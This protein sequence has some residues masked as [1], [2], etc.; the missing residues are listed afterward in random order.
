MGALVLSSLSSLKW[1]M[2]SKLAT[3]SYLDSV[4]KYTIYTPIYNHTV[5]LNSKCD[6][7]LY[8]SWMCID[9]CALFMYFFFS[10]L[11]N[12]STSMQCRHEYCTTNKQ[13]DA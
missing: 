4:V 10:K 9:H 13:R 8:S 11:L 6:H 5:V 2:L 7:T 3:Y 12:V 1:Y